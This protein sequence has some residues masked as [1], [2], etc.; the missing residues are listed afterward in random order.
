MSTQQRRSKRQAEEDEEVVIDEEEEE[1]EK[2]KKRIRVSATTTTTTI[3]TTTTTTTTTSNS[4]TLYSS[5]KSLKLDEADKMVGARSTPCEYEFGEKAQQMINK[6]QR[7]ELQSAVSSV[8]RLLFSHNLATSKPITTKEVKAL[9]ASRLVGKD[10]THK[11]MLGYI[12]HRVAHQL[13]D[14]FGFALFAGDDP[15]DVMAD[16][17]WFFTNTLGNDYLTTLS[18]SVNDANGGVRSQDDEYGSNDEDETNHATAGGG[19]EADRNRGLLL[20]V[21]SIIMIH[22]ME[23]ADEDIVKELIKFGFSTDTAAK[24][25]KNANNMQPS[26]PDVVSKLTK[27]GFITRSK[28]SNGS[29]VYTLGEKAFKEVGK[30]TILQFISQTLQIDLDQEEE[31]ALLCLQDDV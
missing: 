1:E 10:A 12:R 18:N 16:D 30:R 15:H 14:V 19:G 22:H 4:A 9:L 5:A 26:I 17:K 13:K 29:L 28:K 31:T 7:A 25:K 6:F 23:I 20:V 21:L 2:P 3:T 24:L 11:S 8:T 27:Q